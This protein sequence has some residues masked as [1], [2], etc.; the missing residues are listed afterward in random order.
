METVVTMA[1]GRRGLDVS[2]PAEVVPTLITKAAGTP[3]VDPAAA[4]GRALAE[5][6][7]AATLAALAAGR[8]SACIVV[9]DITRPVPNG[10]FLRPMIEIMLAA[11]IALEQITILVAT[12]LHRP[13]GR[14]DLAEIVGDPWVLA[15]VRVLDHDAR[16][17]SELVDL[18]RT[19]TR[20]TPVAI[21]RLFVD[22]ELRI[23]TGLVEPH[24][25]AGWSGGRKVIAPGIAGQE[26]IRTFHSYRFMADPA[27]TQCR[28]VGNPLHEEQLEIAAMVGEVYAVNTIIDEDRRLLFVNF[29]E[30]RA[31]HLDA[32]R[33]AEELSKVPVE[34]SF[35]TVL[36][37][38]AG[39]PL[40]KTYYQTVK[41]MVT[42][43]GILRPGGTLIV[44]SE[45][46]EGFG[47]AEYAD[48]QRRLGSRGIDGFLAE[49]AGKRLADIDEWQTQM[50]LRSQVIADVQL[51][52]GGLD[53]PERA[54]TGVEVIDDV[55]VALSRAV[56]R[57][58]DPHVA[59]IPEGPYLV[60]VIG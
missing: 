16:A 17:S 53:G 15:N 41:A 47:S 48:A 7:D 50:Q 54:A 18:G 13:S 6:V 24:F 51:F 38:A 30:V 19:R 36:T 14:D 2:L 1:Y 45:C 44:V 46:S 9:C 40:D 31:S 57:H 23:V 25:M 43:L 10:V 32:V 27:A 11:G 39:Y 33:R 28:L 3:L 12:G 59:V 52:T 49:L 58:G 55:S 60:P 42:P 22:A 8:R 37:S 21:N 34:Q 29:G 4:V 56:A 20:G 35:S 26:T 5:P